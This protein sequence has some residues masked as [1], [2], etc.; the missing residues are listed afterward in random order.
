MRR[1]DDRKTR[2]PRV[3]AQRCAPG[4]RSAPVV[5]DQCEA[6]DVERIGERENIVDQLV[7]LVRLQLLWAVGSGKAAL[8]GHDQ[9]E[10]VLQP[11]R[12][13]APGAMRFGKAVKQ[14]YGRARAIAG[15]RNIERDAGAQRNAPKLG[16]G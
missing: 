5:A 1:V 13:L 16:H 6:L 8:V 14:D 11:R 15:Q 7:G 10:V 4:D 12:D 9:V 3:A 2:E